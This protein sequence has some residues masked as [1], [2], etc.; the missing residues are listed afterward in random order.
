MPPRSRSPRTCFARAGG[1]SPATVLPRVSDVPCRSRRRLAIPRSGS[2]KA[3][4]G[5]GVTY[6]TRGSRSRPVRPADGCVGPRG[7][8]PCRSCGPTSEVRAKCGTLCSRRASARCGARGARSSRGTSRTRAD[9]PAHPARVGDGRCCIRRSRVRADRPLC[10]RG[11]TR[12]STPSGAG[13]R[14]GDRG[15][16][17]RFDDLRVHSPVLWRGSSRT[18]VRRSVCAQRFHDM[19]RNRRG[20]AG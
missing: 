3:I 13:C 9:W 1:A 5:L 16:L 7:S 15:N 12:T 18:R 14:H 17:C 11:K 20:L 6:G 10:S 2:A 19:M 8:S 4:L